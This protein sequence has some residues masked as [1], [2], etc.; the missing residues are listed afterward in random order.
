MGTTV[1]N[2]DIATVDSG[3]TTVTPPAVSLNPPTPPAGP[4]PVP[5]PYSA[6]SATA[7]KT[8]SNL[9]VGTAKVVVKDSVL[10]ID[11]PANQPSQP[12]GGDVVTHAVKRKAHVTSGS[13]R[14]RA[15]GKPVS[16][17]GDTV[18][19]NVMSGSESVAQAQSVL[20]K[21]GGADSAGDKDGEGADKDK[22]GKRALP[23]SSAKKAAQTCETDPVD[24]ATG[25]VVDEDT[26][27]SLPGLIPLVWKRSYSSGRNDR[28]GA[29]GRGGWTHSFE[30]WV[31]PREGGFTLV[32][33]E[34]REVYFIAAKEGASAFHRGDRKTLT[35]ERGGAFQVRD[36]QTRLVSDYRPLAPGEK[37]LL[38][39]VRD[40]FGHALAFDYQG[41]RLT[42]ISDTAGRELRLTWN[43]QNRIVRLEVWAA[44]PAAQ[45]ETPQAPELRQ[46]V[47][48]AYHVSGELSSV[49][50]ALGHGERYEYDGHHRM[51][52]KT[53]ANG[54][55]FHYEYDGDTGR[56]AH[57]W[58][59]G[60]LLEVQ[61]EIDPA[62][63]TTLVHGSWEPKVYTWN[64]QGLVVRHAA[65]D[66]M[67]VRERVFDDDGY[68]LSESNAAGEKT[69]WKYD[70]G[71]NLV[72]LKDAAGNETRWEYTGD[73]PV[74]RISPDGLTA[75]YTY[76]GN[77]QL[78]AVTHPTGAS[79]AISYDA[80][81]RLATIHGPDGPLWAFGY[82]AHH[83][84]AWERTGRGAVT[85][86]AYDAL[87]RPVGRLDA[88]GRQVRVDYD[89]L[90]QPVTVRFA[91]G[92]S[93]RSVYDARGNV[94][95]FSDPLGQTT[96]MEYGG[97]GVLRKLVRPDGQ[98]WAFHYDQDE[99][100]HEI[101]NPGHESYQF[102][103]DVEGRV[104][105][106]RTF[107]GRRIE[108]TYNKAER[109]CRIAYPDATWREL[110]HDPLG[111]VVEE[112]SPD[113][114]I[115]FERDSFG[116]LLKA[117]LTE[118]PGK[119]VTQLVR[120]T[121][122]R[123]VEEKQN[124][125][126]IRY[127]FDKNGRRAAR[128]LSTGEVTRYSYDAV[129]ALSGVDHDGHKV[130]IERD[131]L[132]RETR[133]HVYAGGVDIQSGY[134]AM[135][136]LEGRRASAPTPGGGVPE[137]LS[138][139]RWRYD[140]IGRV[141]AIDDARWG[142]TD[143]RYDAVG[144]LVSSRR[145]KLNEIFE[146]DVTGTLQNI[147]QDLGEVGRVAPWFHEAGNLL[148]KTADARFENDA[149]GRRT[150][151]VNQ[152]HDA[153]SKLQ[154]DGDEIT[155]YSWDVRD[156]LREV[157]LADGRRVRFYYDAFGRRVRKE[158][159]PAE[160]SDFPRMVK[161]VLDKG[162][163]GLPKPR[164]LEYLWDGDV[165]AAEIE[166]ARTWTPARRELSAAQRAALELASG[167]GPDQGKEEGPR[168][169]VRAFVHEP[170]TFLPLLQSERAGVFTY[171]LDHLGTAKEL[172]DSDGRLAWSAAHSAWG[173]V[174]AVHRD[175]RSVA[176]WGEIDSPFRLLGQY[177]DAE[178]GLCYTRYRYF[179][180]AL[181]RWLSPDPL[182]IKGGANLLG[183]GG[184]PNNFVDPLGL[185]S[186]CKGNL[187]NLKEHYISKKA[188]LEAALGIKLPK[189]SDSNEGQV[190]LATMGR[191]IE[192]GEL[193]H[194]GLATY[195]VGVAPVN[196]Y[197]APNGTVITV[198][199]NGAWNTALT[200]GTGMAMNP[201]YQNPQQLQ[202]SGL[203]PSPTPTAPAASP[204]PGPSPTPGASPGQM[205]LPF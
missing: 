139:R 137:V 193:K 159:L 54:V 146:Y 147:L 179:D 20:I 11:P 17:T 75:Q 171:V 85:R 111:N 5:Y 29:L 47:D 18:V 48:Y 10:D 104:V 40:P 39:A 165:L 176:K 46:W 83:N 22:K 198:W 69:E 190:A 105:R 117:T 204:S 31:T 118:T 62:R 197:Q 148:T 127:D 185:S 49:K 195:K 194:L 192:S 57:A 123:V 28:T 119:I 27:L 1:G 152:T 122:G 70:Q 42:R 34:G 189:W 51:T 124:D 58:G 26:D 162:R 80:H 92:T 53:L 130:A 205:E 129:G 112:H 89:G 3:H 30:S 182:G 96:R 93:A 188:I 133:K 103:Y 169:W 186:L 140:A 66:N 110:L 8:R 72:S 61:L 183:W 161:L 196:V 71:G 201:S 184:N 160:R 173:R 164:V 52:R 131:A 191:M 7:S 55:S 143:Y 25:H 156:R 14:T 142:A 19:A 107:D 41:D 59:D 154:V 16:G 13:S 177:D 109:L 145:G 36:H 163:E 84:A 115:V 2:K 43:D 86:H 120:D 33:E 102:S 4:V 88:L 35:V 67:F 150:L 138:Q 64:E 60:G 199:Q 44:L 155:E 90:G 174:V 87:A 178:T 126:S 65:H 141:S 9:K 68:L 203:P 114:D 6:R 151:R 63:H 181:G 91:D 125:R 200:P 37:A 202:L 101:V 82:D 187:K 144:Q 166:P 180:L 73:L 128:I 157:R 113:G 97:T 23:A 21:A 45:G 168:P 158:V 172:I 77:G 134:D 74:R 98:A 135:D 76:D 15:G 108:Y 24:V 149:R 153:A 94:I 116:R 175:A 100:L 79:Y 106:E 121:F 78:T 38:H 32:D 99:R 167:T 50:N 170:G 12:T 136:R 95:E 81:G 56:V 132:G